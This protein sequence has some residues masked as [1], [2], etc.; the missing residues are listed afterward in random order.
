MTTSEYNDMTSR[1]EKA[2]KI[3]EDITILEDLV[4]AAQTPTGIKIFSNMPGPIYRPTEDEQDQFVLWA[5]RKIKELQQQF[6][7]L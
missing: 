5:R 2:S 4:S 3:R 7:E 1:I 6:K